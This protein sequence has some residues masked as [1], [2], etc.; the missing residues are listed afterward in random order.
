MPQVQ[1]KKKRKKE[2]EKKIQASRGKCIQMG[3]EPKGKTKR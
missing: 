2:R 1:P 3:P